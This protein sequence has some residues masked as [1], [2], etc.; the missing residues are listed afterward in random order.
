MK[1]QILKIAKVKSEKEF[2]KKFPTEEAFM[3]KHG[4]QLKKAAMGTQMVQTQLKQLTDFGN[5]PIAQ[6]GI[7]IIPFEQE[8]IKA[9]ATIMGITPE[10]LM[11]QEAAQAAQA[12]GG[13][14]GSDMLGQLTSLISPD[15]IKGLIA[16]DGDSLPKAY[17]G[18]EIGGIPSWLTL[19]NNNPL[20]AP[21]TY[22]KWTGLVGGSNN[23]AGQQVVTKAA[24]DKAFGAGQLPAGAGGGGMSASLKTAG[25]SALGALPSLIGSV[26]AIGQRSK[27][28]GKLKVGVKVSD[29]V[30]RAAESRPVYQPNQQIWHPWDTPAQ[31]GQLGNSY[32][33]NT[34][35]LSA[36]NGTQIQNTYAPTNTL[37]DDLGY[38][39]LNESDVKQYQNGGKAKKVKFDPSTYK[40]RPEAESS[41]IKSVTNSLL[42]AGAGGADSNDFSNYS[43][44]INKYANMGND[45]S[46][47]YTRNT[48]IGTEEFF[49]NTNQ[50]NPISQLRRGKEFINLSPDQVNAYKQK[51]LTGTGGFEQG[52]KV[53][54][55]QFGIEMLSGPAGSIGGGIGSLI[56]GGDFE[57]SPEGDIGSTL[58]SIAG[59]FIL[60]GVGTVIGGALGGLIGGIFGGD[61]QKQMKELQNKINDN[62]DLAAGQSTIQGIDQQFSA[63][64]KDG[65][66]VSH[67]WQ[68]QVI[69]KFGDYDVKDL[70]KP[71]HDADMLRAGGTVGFEHYTPPSAEAMFTGRRDVPYQMDNGGRMNSTNMMFDTDKYPRAAHGAQVALDGDL[72]VHQGKAD[73]ISYNPFLPKGGETVMFKGPSHANGGMDISYGQNGVE[74]EGGEP[75]VILKDGG[76]V[77][78]DENLVIYG[79]I[80]F[81]ELGAKQLGDPKAEGKKIK[82]YMND[83]SKDETKQNKLRQKGLEL[84]DETDLLR[85]GTVQAIDLGTTAKLK[86]AAQRKIDGAAIQEAYNKTAKEYGYKDAGKFIDDVRKGSVKQLEPIDDSETAQNGVGL[87]NNYNPELLQKLMYNGIQQNPIVTPFTKQNM[88]AQGFKDANNK[89]VIAAAPSVKPKASSKTKATTP[90]SADVTD[91]LNAMT[92]KGKGLAQ[93][94]RDA[95]GTYGQVPTGVLPDSAP[96]V[97]LNSID[98]TGTTAKTA[99]NTNNDKWKTILG[100]VSSI[101]PYLRPSNAEPLD[102]SQLSGEMLALASNQLEGVQAQSFQPMLD[103]PY[104][105]SLQDQINMIDAQTNAAIRALGN[106]PSAQSQIMANAIEAK[107][108]VLGEQFRINQANKAGIYAKNRDLLN[109]SQ[110][111][112]LQIFDK[113]YERQSQAKSNTKA[114]AIGALNSINSKIAQNKLENKQLGVYENLYAYRFGPNGQAY[115][116]NAPAQFNTEGNPMASNRTGQTTTD[117]SG[118]KLLPVYNKDGSVKG[119]TVETAKNGAKIKARNSSIVKAVKSL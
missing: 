103:Q 87:P 22:N 100:A 64:R 117:A 38:E 16:K 68:P 90:V 91:A 60:P 29:L 71:P 13:G 58:G 101:A 51:V 62:T 85:M 12:S 73:T 92:A 4:K 52:G 112:N 2:Y 75:G 81:D 80:K 39:P 7:G 76:N 32:G 82:N 56:G 109:Q 41:A 65:G 106:D 20:T 40:S 97:P 84:I 55:A 44:T 36:A 61:E 1:D 26:Q 6:N 37:Y 88:L 53:D 93:I 70:L 77:Q 8:R 115:N 11:K 43:T 18:D 21:A 46:Y 27:N 108:K 86:L 89:P 67:D 69:T 114:Q 116:L 72:K 119:Y 42:S 28:K 3:A 15:M 57:G 48:P 10:E 17:G 50:G 47:M 49:H 107:N 102:P 110:L 66:W 74:V 95:I 118:N 45:T 33:Q 31:P 14:G 35:Y 79:N 23:A 96:V 94:R 54:K 99:N 113:Q 111:Q 34:N 98:S 24:T 19:G 78:K 83:V 9:R 59:S 30:K 104:D 63:S 5:P 25:M 105:I